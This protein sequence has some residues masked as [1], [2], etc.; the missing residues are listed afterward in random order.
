[1]ET[2]GSCFIFWSCLPQRLFNKNTINVIFLFNFYKQIE[3]LKVP[4][5][6]AKLIK[7]INLHYMGSLL[8]LQI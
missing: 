1:M 6:I 4:N 5:A 3:W 8:E 2:Y 7:N